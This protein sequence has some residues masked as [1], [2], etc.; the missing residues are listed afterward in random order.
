M[1]KTVPCLAYHPTLDCLCVCNGDEFYTD[2]EPEVL[3]Q[4]DQ[5]L[6]HELVWWIRQR[7]R[8]TR[9]N[10][11]LWSETGYLLQGDGKHHEALAELLNLTGVKTAPTQMTRA[12]VNDA[13]DALDVLAKAAAVMFRRSADMAMY[14]GPD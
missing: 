1:L 13:R 11:L 5:R 9:R 3:D 6:F 2:G 8:S 12:T 14:I 10:L 7:A 4:V